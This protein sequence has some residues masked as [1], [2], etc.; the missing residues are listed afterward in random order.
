MNLEIVIII[1]FPFLKGLQTYDKIFRILLYDYIKRN[2]SSI[3]M[4]NP[5]TIKDTSAYDNKKKC[6][7]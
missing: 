3:I 1:I 5:Y 2:K 6:R 4:E 7:N